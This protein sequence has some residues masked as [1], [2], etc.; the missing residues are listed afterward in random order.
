MGVH[1][2]VTQLLMF[3]RFQKLLCIDQLRGRWRAGCI[4]LFQTLQSMRI[5]RMS[6]DFSIE[7]ECWVFCEFVHAMWL[8][9][10]GDNRYF[11]SRHGVNVAI[12]ILEW[13]HFTFF[14]CC[15][16]LPKASIGWNYF[17]LWI[18]AMV[19][20]I[21]KYHQCSIQKVARGKWVKY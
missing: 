19:M 20:W 16:R 15:S 14:F 8:W 21:G 17:L 7:E 10:R 12:L 1:E 2:K 13:R 9:L 5:K 18:S 11:S 3:T 6:E 4:K